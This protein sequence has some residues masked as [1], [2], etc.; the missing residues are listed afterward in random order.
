M[1]TLNMKNMFYIILLILGIFNASFAIEIYVEK[2][3]PTSTISI[4]ITD[5][6]YDPNLN[7][8]VYI[9]SSKY[10]AGNKWYLWYITD[11]RYEHYVTRAFFT[12]RKYD[13]HWIVYITKHKSEAKWI[14]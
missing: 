7:A 10:E 11:N 2:Q 9:A 4:Y 14:R 6:K 3:R 5:N 1:G 13:A 12:T 8:I